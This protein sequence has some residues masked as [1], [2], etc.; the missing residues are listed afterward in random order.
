[1]S[2]SPAESSAAAP[3]QPPIITSQPPAIVHQ[4]LHLHGITAAD[5]AGIIARQDAGRVCGTL[6]EHPAIEE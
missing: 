4:H 2:A 5:L 6:D 1:M 3:I